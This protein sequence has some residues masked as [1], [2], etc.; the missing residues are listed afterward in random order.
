MQVVTSQKTTLSRS[1]AQIQAPVQQSECVKVN[2]TTKFRWT[3][4]PSQLLVCFK[5][6]LIADHLQLKQ[7][8]MDFSLPWNFF[9]DPFK[10]SQSATQHLLVN[11]IL[12]II[13]QWLNYT[14]LHFL[15]ASVSYSFF[16]DICN[17]NNF[18]L[19]FSWS[20]LLKLR[21]LCLCSLFL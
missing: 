9:L 11:C 1:T 21:R 4:G 16:L 18:I 7:L 14:C 13:C 5:Q 15:G 3:K 6:Y 8:Q 10:F 12:Y 17:C 19:V 2:M 20:S